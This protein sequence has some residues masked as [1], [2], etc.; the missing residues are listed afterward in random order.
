MWRCDTHIE[1]DDPFFPG[2]IGHGVRSDHRLS[3]RRRVTPNVKFVPVFVILLFNIEVFVLHDMGRTFNLDVSTGF[4]TDILTFGQF[5]NQLFDEGGYIAIGANGTLPFLSFEDFRWHFDFHIL[6]NSD[7][8]RQAMSVT[9]FTFG[10]MTTF[11]WQDI[12][13]TFMNHHTTLCTGTTSP[14]G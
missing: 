9:S 14:T 10:D 11:C 3:Y 12:S 2:V 6:F 13:T 8:T 1:H 4:E 7:L 5:K